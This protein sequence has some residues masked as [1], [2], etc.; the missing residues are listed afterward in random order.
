[1]SHS[2][3]V[4]NALF[5]GDVD[6]SAVDNLAELGALL[7]GAT[8]T[9]TVT[10]VNLAAPTGFSVSGGPITGAGTLTLSTAL[11]G[12]L[13]GNGSG[14]AVAMAGTDFISPT[15][16]ENL[17]NKTLTTGNT[18]NS[19]TVIKGG[20]MTLGSDATGDIYYRNN[21]GNLTRLGIGTSGQV[22]G[23][24]S[25]VPQWQTISTLTLT[26]G[27]I[28]GIVIG[29]TAPAAA[30]VTTF[31][32]KAISPATGSGTF[33]VSAGFLNI[34]T[35]T[36][37]VAFYDPSNVLQVSINY[38]TGEVLSALNLVLAG[39]AT[40][41]GLLIDSTTGGRLTIGNG[42]RWTVDNTASVTAT[43]GATI[44]FGA[45]GDVVYTDAT[46]TLTNKTITGTFSGIW[47]GPCTMDGQL[48]VNNVA[49][50]TTYLSVDSTNGILM[51][52]LPTS[53]P[54]VAGTL[55]S[56]GVPS[57]GVPKALMVSGG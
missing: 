33:T 18:I 1:M 43:D 54:G 35:D 13:K 34:G 47:S 14:F 9:G 39:G 48:I 41:N 32:V 56:D 3:P 44:N 4:H 15:G 7:L 23:L 6:M 20:A 37:G 38:D 30:T 10:S 27:T 25:G 28:N 46:Q 45:G 49:G 8:G 12:V 2:F 21:S 29:G 11:S 57:A 42:K 52:Q 51:Q 19:G 5:T 16:A 53:D 26:G 31:T 24:N 50:D 55:Y 40:I 17:S 36:S 22:L